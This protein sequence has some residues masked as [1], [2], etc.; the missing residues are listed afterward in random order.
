MTKVVLI[1]HGRST[2]NAEGILAGR[3]PG[4][5]L[6]ETG[7]AQAVRLGELLA[8]TAIAG[9]FTS[10]VQRCRETATLAGFASAEVVE[11]LSECDYGA[12]TGPASRRCAARR[13]G[14]TSRSPLEGDVPRGESMVE[15]FT[16]AST[17]VRDLAGRHGDGD[18]IVVFSHG[19]PIKAILADAFGMRLD[20]FQRLHVSPA[21]VSIIEFHHDRPLVVC[22]NAG[23][24]L[25]SLLA[26]RSAPTVGGETSPNPRRL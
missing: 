14:A 7:R 25:G 22:I 18:T 11:G 1:R 10:P 17:A 12:W 3:A 26:A 6:D 5:P 13:S 16:R 9:A 2:A 20:D 19:D 15:M 8:G 24:D 21:G 4:V 23:G